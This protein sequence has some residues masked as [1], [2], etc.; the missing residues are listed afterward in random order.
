MVQ[1][2]QKETAKGRLVKLWIITQHEPTGDQSSCAKDSGIDILSFEQFRRHHID[3]LSYMG[4]RANYPFGSARDPKND[5]RK[6]SGVKYQP[7]SIRRISAEGPQLAVGDLVD[8]LTN[9]KTVVVLGDYGVGKS[10][11]VREVYVKLCA[12]YRDDSKSSLPIAINLRDLGVKTIPTRHCIAT[13][14]KWG[15]RRRQISPGLSI[16]QTC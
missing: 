1:Y 10:L 7:Q 15:S 11:L 13:P 8:A 16:R 6:V 2:R 12:K 3:G 4:F 14:R 9:G 5:D